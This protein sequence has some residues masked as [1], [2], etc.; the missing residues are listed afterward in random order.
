M[1][2]VGTIKEDFMILRVKVIRGKKINVGDIKRIEIYS[3][4]ALIDFLEEGYTIEGHIQGHIQGYEADDDDQTEEI[5]YVTAYCEHPKHFFILERANMKKC[6]KHLRKVER[7]QSVKSWIET[8][9]QGT[10]ATATIIT[11][12]STLIIAVVSI[13]KC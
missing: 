1:N 5:G 2:E 6:D 7:R 3:V 13:K 10:V 4:N 8:Y 9:G 11:A 12:I